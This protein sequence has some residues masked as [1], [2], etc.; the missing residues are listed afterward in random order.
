[1]ASPWT[2][3]EWGVQEGSAE[4]AR[5]PS[6]EQSLNCRQCNAQQQRSRD[7]VI[8][9]LK[10]SFHPT[11]RAQRT[12][13]K[14]LATDAGDTRKLRN[15]RNSRSSRKR[16]NGQNA[17]ILEAVRYLFLRCVYV[18]FVALHALRWIVTMAYALSSFTA[19]LTNESAKLG[20]VNYCLHGGS[21]GRNR[22]A[23]TAN[24]SGRRRLIL[25]Y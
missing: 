23:A 18:A 21:T 7:D 17:R 13:R 22:A 10:L 1:M 6:G 4:T 25:T 15:K 14:A 8:L 12:Q 9:S 24:M 19:P 11:Q 16:R 20:S 3:F 5:T 2:E